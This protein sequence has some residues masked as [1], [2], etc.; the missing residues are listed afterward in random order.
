MAAAEGGAEGL[1]AVG[2]QLQ[3]VAVSDRRDGRIVGGLAEQI[4]GD[5]GAGLEPPLGLDGEDGRLQPLGIEV[6]GVAG[7]D[8]DE[9]PARRPARG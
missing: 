7:R 6:V 3:A 2:D 4:D 8:V 5:D 1:G 9:A